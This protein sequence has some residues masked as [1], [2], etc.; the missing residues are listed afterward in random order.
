MSVP[1][2]TPSVTSVRPRRSR[3]LRIL[4][5]L[6]LAVLA[7]PMLLFLAEVVMVLAGDGY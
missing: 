5:Y 7:V 2:L 1:E 6:V 3:T 4:L